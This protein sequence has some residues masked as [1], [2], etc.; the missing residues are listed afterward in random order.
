MVATICQHPRDATIV[1]DLEL[2]KDPP[3][4]PVVNGLTK[5]FRAA[6][7][8][9]GDNAAS[10]ANAHCGYLRLGH[11]TRSGQALVQVLGESLTRSGCPPGIIGVALSWHA[12]RREWLER[13]LLSADSRAPIQ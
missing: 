7:G 6:R 11:R 2:V 13:S 5:G 12:P 9:R 3:L 10:L 4:Q 1:G 8:E